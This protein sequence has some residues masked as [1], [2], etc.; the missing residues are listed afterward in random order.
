MDNGE[1]ASLDRKTLEWARKNTWCEEF[2]VREC[3]ACGLFYKPELGHDC[4]KSPKL[5]FN[6]KIGNIELRACPASLA[7]LRDDDP[8][9]TID[10]V[11]WHKDSKGKP[12]CFSIAY[13]RREDEGYKLKFVGARPFL[14]VDDSRVP[15]L[16]E[17]MQEAQV[18]LDAWFDDTE[19]MKDD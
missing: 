18:V 11:M 17:A 8:N 14:Y 3:K 2:A 9:V 15:E 5:E 12:Y 10:I 1:H 4:D 16:W 19:A 7:R 13:W 6:R